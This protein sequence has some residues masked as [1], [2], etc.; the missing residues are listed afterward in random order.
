MAPSS[1]GVGALLAA[2][3]GGE[4][5]GHPGRADL[6][7]TWKGACLVRG[8]RRGRSGDRL[9]IVDGNPHTG[10]H[11]FP[12]C[13]VAG[14]TGQLRTRWTPATGPASQDHGV[15]GARVLSIVDGNPHTGFHAFPRW[16]VAGKPASSPR[17]GEPSDC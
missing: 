13:Y 16:Y 17:D 14:K 4:T 2:P 6:A 12:R 15:L 10:F 8:A 3:L 9:T 5:E 11:A 1:L 7:R